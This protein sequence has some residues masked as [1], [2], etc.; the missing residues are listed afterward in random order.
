MTRHYVFFTVILL[1][2]FFPVGIKFKNKTQNFLEV[3]NRPL[4]GAISPP[5]KSSLTIKSLLDG[6]FQNNYEAY[7]ASGLPGRKLMTRIY[8]Q[9]LFSVF[10]STD[11]TSIQVGNKK[12]LFEIGY[13][14]AYFI[15]VGTDQKEALTQKIKMLKIMEAKLNKKDKILALIITPSK[16]AIYPEHLPMCYQPYVNMKNFGDYG[17]NFY[18]TF[19]ESCKE[20]DLD[21]LDLHEKFL[22][23]KENHKIIF[24]V[25]GIHWTGSAI[26]YFLP[27]FVQYLS[28]K[29]NYPLGS[30]ITEKETLRLNTPFQSDGDLEDLLNLASP[31]YNFYS[32]HIEL[33]SRS[34]LY[35]PNI[36]VCGGSFNW[37]WLNSIFGNQNQ[38]EVIFSKIDFSYYNSYIISYPEGN[39]IAD[40]TDDFASI[41]EN[42]I[43]VIELNE[44]A[45]HPDVPQFVFMENFL[46]Y[47]NESEKPENN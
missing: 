15:E 20:F 7:Y 30:I 29:L 12:Y 37:N 11:N 14:K 6:T 40:A 31:K 28:T 22:Y 38:G 32:P 34:S 47:L 2:I 26:S 39:R 46:N 8:N 27:A 19:I 45:I 3:L 42:D 4:V 33:S 9:I 21:F 13:P 16:A 41:M 25:S 1:F 18:D 17:N 24:S 36:F 35:R 44:Q 23:E 10:R 5:Q 43:I